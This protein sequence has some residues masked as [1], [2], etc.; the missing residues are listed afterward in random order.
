MQN[1]KIEVPITTGSLSEAK[2]VAHER[3]TY[4]EDYGFPYQLGQSV[5]RHLNGVAPTTV[6][7]ES[8]GAM[9]IK[10]AAILVG[11]TYFVANVI[12]RRREANR[13]LRE[14]PNDPEALRIKKN[15]EETQKLVT[16]LKTAIKETRDEIREE[17]RKEKDDETIIVVDENG[18]TPPTK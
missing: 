6:D 4:D 11:V 17:L 5:V 12:R 18:D 16:T 2:E 9:S 15:R 13:L 8:K 3:L 7:T 1:Y 14:Q 10:K